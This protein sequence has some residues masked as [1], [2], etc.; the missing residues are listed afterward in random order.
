MG[1]QRFRRAIDRMMNTEDLKS[2][3]EK[4]F[5]NE[6]SK[7]EVMQLLLTLEESDG[8]IVEGLIDDVLTTINWSRIDVLDFKKKG[9]FDRVR[10]E[11]AGMSGVDN[12]HEERAAKRHFRFKYGIPAAAVLL[13]ALGLIFYM[14]R[15]APPISRIVQQDQHEI[16]LP[17]YTV[18][19]LILEN[20]K[21]ISLDDLEEG[22][23]REVDGVRIEKRKGGRFYFAY[24]NASLHSLAKRQ[25]FKTAKGSSAEIILADGSV[26]KLNSASSLSFP[27]IFDNT[28]QVDLNGEAYFEVAHN[29]DAPFRVKTNTSEIQVLGTKFNA[30]A[31]PEELN[32]EVTLS[33]GSVLV[34]SKKMHVRLV[35]GEQAIVSS[36]SGDIVSRTVNLEEMMAWKD[37]YFRFTDQSIKQVLYELSKWYDIK[38]VEILSESSDRFSGSVRRSQKLSDLLGQLERISSLK[39]KIVEGRV[40]VM[41]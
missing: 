23:V 31:Y 14:K 39:F 32:S 3:L 37:G 16:T 15:E 5:K 29:R 8:A 10:A 7:E 25:V 6:L 41:K 1:N 19:T 34:S 11:I 26:V 27:L 21:P 40:R 12:L 22:Q 2:R 9:V 4:Y 33:E 20:G 38:G 30:S 28:R 13:I 17:P 18:A 24:A 36:K 35:P